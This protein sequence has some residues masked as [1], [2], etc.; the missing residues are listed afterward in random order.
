[1]GR[2]ISRR[3]ATIAMGLAGL[4]TPACA[5][6]A[7]AKPAPN[8]AATR[9]ST[10]ELVHSVDDVK[11][12]SYGTPPVHY[13]VSAQG[14]VPSKGYTGAQLVIKSNKPDSSGLITLYFAVEP[15]ASTGTPA[16]SLI[17]VIR[18]FD[19]VAGIK[20]FVVIAE[21]NEKAVAGR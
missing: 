8:K 3:E 11:L 19:E 13:I 17:S 14:T 10:W 21:S 4:S 18:I 12:E 1:M 16:P 20:R 2:K 9:N 6:A 15:P 7:A 5:E